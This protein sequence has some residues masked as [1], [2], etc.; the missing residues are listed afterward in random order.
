LGGSTTITSNGD[1][2][3]TWSSSN[4]NVISI[5]SNGNI[6]AV[7]P[8]SATITYSVAATSVGCSSSLASATSSIN[9]V[10]NLVPIVSV[11]DVTI[12]PGASATLIAVPTVNG[13]TFIW[14]PGGQ[15]SNSIV[16]TPSSSATYDVVYSINGCSSAPAS[17]IVNVIQLNS[18]SFTADE[19][20]GCAPLTV[21]FNSLGSNLSDCVWSFSNGET[22]SGCSTTHTFDIPGCYDVTLISNE[23]GCSVSSGQNSFICVESQPIS[24]F[25]SNPSIFSESSDLASFYNNSL[26]ATSYIWNFGDGQISNVV[27]PTHYYLNTI[28]GIQVQLIA[29]SDSGCSDTSS[30]I[31]P[32]QE[33]ETF[34]VPNSFTPDSDEHNQ[35]FVPVFTSGFDPYNF[36][37]LIFNRWGEL[38]FESNDSKTGWDGTYGLN[39]IK[40]QDGIYTWEISFKSLYNDKRKTVVGHVNLLR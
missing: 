10:V 38:V 30:I 6:D 13:G 28:N 39:G 12:C 7:G 35:V 31:I 34:Y 19:T 37:M 32:F 11:N 27:N 23:N 25:S 3:G 5:N 16:V 4:T 14:N 20:V 22:A 8:G 1:A 18:V 2:G 9:I 33:G 29:I 36:Q 24:N 26:G 40:V 17:A 21:Q 15:S